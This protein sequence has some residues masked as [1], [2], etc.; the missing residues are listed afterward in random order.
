M[1]HWRSIGVCTALV[2]GVVLPAS[3][4]DS[5]GLNLRELMV[6][7]VAPNTNK[8]WSAFEIKTDNEWLELEHATSAVI[9][10]AQLIAL[11]GAD[12]AY[13]TQ[14]KNEDWQ[15]FVAQLIGAARKAQLAIQNH[16]EEALF[17]A[18]NDELYPPCENCHNVYLPR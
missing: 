1:K 12:G 16:D 13:A 18:G 11:G 17:N 9:A 2:F 15:S 5:P 6:G 10:A 8:I 4:Q 3:S 7:V 14:S